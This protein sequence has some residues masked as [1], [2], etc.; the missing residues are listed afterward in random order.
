MV[1][2]AMPKFSLKNQILNP[3]I[4]ITSSSSVQKVEHYKKNF[5]INNSQAEIIGKVLDNECG[6]SL[7]QGPP[8]TGKSELVVGL[9][10][11]LKES[12]NI[13]GTSLVCAPSNSIID[14][15]VKKL[16]AGI[17]DSAGNIIRVN[18]VRLGHSDSISN[19]TRDDVS[20]DFLAEKMMSEIKGNDKRD[21]LYYKRRV[22][23]EADIICSTLIESGHDILST[24]N[25]DF[26]TI[27]I[28]NATQ[29]T[30]LS[31]LIPLKYN[32]KRVILIGDPN[33]SFP[34][35]SSE[36]AK[37]CYY[38]QSLFVRIQKNC[39]SSVNMLKVQYR[40]HKEICKFP[41]QFFY[42][43]LIK[44]SGNLLQKRNQPWHRNK[45]FP[46]YKFFNVGGITKEEKGAN[47][48]VHN[49]YEA[50]IIAQACKRLIK[51]F[52]QVNVG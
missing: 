38:D 29:S 47:N 41:N 2:I 46:P 34:A 48:L 26:N 7:I 52:S 32:P 18:I 43:S 49:N 40:M 24:M 21:L 33:Q 30:E 4:S 23:E 35:I 27:I 31:S 3:K 19:G 37:Q 20:L 14:I 50:K 13:Q 42:N 17:Y 9:I 25:I 1:L 12:S 10:S 36:M 45:L 51:D 8:G 15:S 6:F 22:L 44:D 28:D 39:P 5:H 16:K 11:A